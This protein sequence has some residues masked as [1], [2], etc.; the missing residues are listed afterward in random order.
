MS[1]S[2]PS[3]RKIASNR[4]WTP[5]GLICNPLLT[6]DAEGRVLSLDVCSEPDRMA[7]TEF[8]AGVL[9]PDFPADFQSVFDGMRAQTQ[10]SLTEL[11]ARLVPATEGVV[12]VIWGLDY[13]TMRLTAQSQIRKL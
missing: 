11:L 3:T 1:S 7:S 4:A 5:G 8:Y 6:L 2:V 13:E 10:L 9:V 12:V